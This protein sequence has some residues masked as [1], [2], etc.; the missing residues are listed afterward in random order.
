MKKIYTV[1]VLLFLVQSVVAQ[2]KAEQTSAADIAKELTNPATDKST[3]N[4]NFEYTT[5]RGALPNSSGQDGFI[6]SF[7]PAFPFSLGDG[8]IF[9]VR[10]LIPFN[11]SRPVF[12]AGKSDFDDESSLIGDITTDIF[13]G[14]TE[15]SGW[16]TGLGAVTVLP[17][18][19]DEKLAGKS[20]NAGPEVLIVK[21]DDW[22]AAGILAT[23]QWDVTGWNDDYVSLSTLQY[24][25]SFLLE[26]GWSI[27][28]SPII[29]Y[30]WAAESRNKW[31]VQW[32]PAYPKPVS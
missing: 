12:N 1:I 23:H 15:K 27:A 10:P 13:Y 32:A 11:F 14:K 26:D 4:F 5:Y 7:Q 18:A 24:I 8:R 29:T 19:T 6:M 16:V 20:F 9:A 21:L 3:L 31:A 22:G 25:Y 28:A 30:D 17:T 2:E